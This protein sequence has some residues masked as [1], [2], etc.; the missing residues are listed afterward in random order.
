MCCMVCTHIAR[1]AHAYNNH[2]AVLKLFARA[3]NKDMKMFLKRRI[4]TDMKIAHET[5]DNN[6]QRLVA[7]SLV[8]TCNGPLHFD[9]HRY[10]PHALQPALVNERAK[11][12]E[13]PLSWIEIEDQPN[14]EA[15]SI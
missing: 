6:V 14:H 3:I 13:A 12:R 15:H 10:Q 5:Y 9:K 2:S 4:R 8:F 7:L 1:V 11:Q